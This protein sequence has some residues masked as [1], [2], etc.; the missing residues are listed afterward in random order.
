MPVPLESRVSTAVRASLAEAL[1]L[2]FPTWC[3][4]CDELDVSLC[5][6]CAAALQPHPAAR[7]LDGFEVRSALPFD[8]VAARV[9]R[10]YKQEGRTG[11]ARPLGA[12]LA[13]AVGTVDADTVIVPVP[14]SRA[15]IRRRGYRVA[16]LLA[17]RADLAP[18]RL[19][20]PAAVAADQR[21]LG[22]EARAANVHG[23]LRAGPVAGLRVIVVDD[24][25]TTGA[26][27]S[28]AVRVLRTAGADVL[29]AATVAATARRSPA[30]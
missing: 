14:S 10:A 20:H 24:V 9:I 6:A 27:L 1:S 22:R 2:V 5:G 8:G 29:R 18:R 11:L 7:R 23:T 4:G 3:A 15:A 26:T 21:E 16:E 12:A 19:L 30:A 17:R 13:A 28:E 25:V